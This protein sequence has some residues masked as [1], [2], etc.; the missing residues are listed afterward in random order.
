M[1]VELTVEDISGREHEFTLEKNGFMLGKQQTKVLLQ[2]E[3]L[4]NDEKITKEYYPEMEAWL[5]EA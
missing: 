1:G 2:T 3:D 4:V 5:K